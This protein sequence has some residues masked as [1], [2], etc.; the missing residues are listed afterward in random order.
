MGNDGK[1]P[2]AGKAIIPLLAALAVLVA[3]IGLVGCTAS[4]T[5]QGR[6]MLPC[7]LD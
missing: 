4:R 1:H 2:K 6:F 5:E 7:S 3:C